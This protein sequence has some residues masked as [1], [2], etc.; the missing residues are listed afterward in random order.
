MVT[1]TY[2]KM[3][4]IVLIGLCL[5]GCSAAG[6]GP[7][8]VI[9][10]LTLSPQGV[11]YTLVQGIAER[12]EA[13]T[14][15]PVLVQDGGTPVRRAPMITRGNCGET[16][17]SISKPHRVEW[18][19]VDNDAECLHESVLLH[20]VGHA[21]CEHGLLSDVDDRCHSPAGIMRSSIQGRC[22]DEV[23]LSSICSYQDCKTF[24]PEC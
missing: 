1:Y 4:Q 24:M 20:E 13:A 10:P 19:H 7:G 5:F 14:G 22:I 11:D 18:V 17:V 12:W 6:D 23:S 21:V 8:A 16:G 3:K 9:P 2:T 15:L